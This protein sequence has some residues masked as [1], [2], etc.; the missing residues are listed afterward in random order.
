M[1]RARRAISRV[2]G[3]AIRDCV[4]RTLRREYHFSD[5]QI[6]Q[7]FEYATGDWPFDLG[8]MLALGK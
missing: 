8:R 7:C 6:D 5:D 4:T 3:T 2:Q 1:S